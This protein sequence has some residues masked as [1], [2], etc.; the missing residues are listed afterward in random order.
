M[1]M[2]GYKFYVFCFFNRLSEQEN[3][4]VLK[5]LASNNFYFDGGLRF[6]LLGGM[7]GMQS[8]VML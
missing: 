2:V 7:P 3:V 4:R 8:N 6:D 1:R 5:N